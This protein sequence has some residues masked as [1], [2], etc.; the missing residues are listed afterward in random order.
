MTTEPRTIE[1]SQK[2]RSSEESAREILISGRENSLK[3]VSIFLEGI[4]LIVMSYSFSTYMKN[5]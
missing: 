2:S 4:I 5:L 3:L 1:T